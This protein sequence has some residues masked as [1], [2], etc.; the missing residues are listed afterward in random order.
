[1]KT[2]FSILIITLA[3]NFS[4][5]Q[6]DVASVKS[7]KDLTAIKETGTG[8]ITLP[9]GMTKAD[10]EAKS[11][12]YTLYFTIDFDEK[13]KVATI[14][15]VDNN[16][17]SRQV[18]VRFLAACEIQTVNVAGDSIHRDQVFEKYLR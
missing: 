10:V 18:I 8:Y 14:N 13:S 9:S 17:R 12:Y 16:E 5:G 2:L 7:A 3:V 6:N 1:M 11:K 15:M 4:F